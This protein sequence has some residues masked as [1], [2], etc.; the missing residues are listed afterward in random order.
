EPDGDLLNEKDNLP[1]RI[2]LLRRPPPARR[3]A[4]EHGALWRMLAAMTPHALLLQ[5]SGLGA[6]K[7]LLVQHAARA[8]SAAPQI[9]AIA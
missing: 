6:R 4:R 5:P 1:G 9:D 2:A 8:S 3:F 7:A